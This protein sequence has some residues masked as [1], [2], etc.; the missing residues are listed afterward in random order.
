MNVITNTPKLLL[1]GIGDVTIRLA[2]LLAVGDQPVDLVM[3]G[4][5]LERA[6]RF[7][8]LTK[9]AASNL[10]HFCDVEALELDLTDIDRTAA[11]IRRIQ[12]DLIFMGA[13]IQAARAIMDVSPQDFKKLDQAQLG[14]WLPMHLALN[15]ELMQAVRLAESRAIVVNAAYPDAVGPALAT[16]GL[17][18]HIG[19]GNIANVVPGITWAAAQE[20]D[21]HVSEIDINLVCHHYFSHHVHRFG[22]ARGIPYALAVFR[23]GEEV[24]VDHEAVFARLAANLRRQGGKDGQQVTATSAART[25][26]ALLGS[27]TRRLHSPAPGG[28]IGGYPLHVSRER[29]DLALP[30]GLSAAEAQDVNRRA[31]RL[32]GI[33]SISPDG[34]IVFAPEQMSVLNDLLGYDCGTLHVTDAR[35]A[36]TELRMKYELYVERLG[37]PQFA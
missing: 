16:V 8:N 10:G 5:S 13:S 32:D 21:A 18:P 1:I 11:E 24:A 29:I 25:V 20:L 22:E 31:Q 9:L 2:H 30:K 15:Y 12:P 19:I 3:A 36:A 27:E 4:R 17:A 33:E 23:D 35:E 7:A 6:T 37:A 28:M 14:P 26:W 34:T